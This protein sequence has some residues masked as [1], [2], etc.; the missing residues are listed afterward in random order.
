MNNK[1]QLIAAD[2]H[3]LNAYVNVPPAP[4]AALIVLQEIFGVNH[5]IR[6]MVDRFAA[7]GFLAIAPALFDRVR[8][9]IELKY[10]EPGM[11][12]GKKLAMSLKQEGV[13]EDIAAALAYARREL[14]GAKVGVVG[15]C[16][17]GSYAWLSALYQDPKAAVCYYGSMVA[18]KA[19]E[20]PKCPVMM[21]FGEKDK[22][23]PMEDVQTIRTAHPHIPVFTYDAGHGFSCDDRA[24]FAPEAAQQAFA[25]TVSFFREH[26]A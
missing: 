15:Y 6:T 26:L 23:I 8:P 10:D 1:V 17:G 22:S 3:R 24:S 12:D 5:H 2:G 11:S 20:T 18:K 16:F 4:K 21:H 25:R 19:Q 7:E 9:N 13:L 14:P